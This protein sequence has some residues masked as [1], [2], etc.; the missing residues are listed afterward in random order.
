MSAKDLIESVAAGE[1]PRSV[2]EA[3][4]TPEMEDKHL[5]SDIKTLKAFARDMETLRKAGKYKEL[6]QKLDHVAN[7]FIP[8]MRQSTK[9]LM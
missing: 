1:S 2:L 4:D 6:D 3:K 9:A 8:I 5:F 7:K